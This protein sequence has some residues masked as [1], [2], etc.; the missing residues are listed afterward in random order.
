MRAPLAPPRLS[1]PRNVDADA[2]AVATSWET[3]RPEA[4]IFAFSA[5]MS[6]FPDQRM[7]HRGDRV[8]PRQ[9]FLRNER[10]EIARDRPHVAVRQLEPRPG[11]RVGE[12]VRVLV[13]APRNLF[14]GRV[15]PQRE[16]RGQHG[17]HMPLRRVEGIG[18]RRLGAFRLPLLGAGRALGQLPFVA[19]QV[20]EEVVA[21]LRRRLRPGDLRAAG[22]RVGAL[23]GAE[24]ALPAEA[25]LLDRGGFRLRAHQRGIAGAVGLAEGVT[26]GDQRD[27]FLV[28]HRH[29]GECL[30]NISRRGERIRVAVRPFRVDV[31]QAHLHGAERVLKIA[32]AGV[33]LI[34]QPFAFGAPV[35]VLIRLPDILAPAA[36]TE[37]LEAHRLRGATLPAR[38]IRSA[39]EIL[40]PYFCLIGHKQPARFVEV[41]VVRPAVERREALLAGAGAAAA[42][43][44]AV[45][46]G[47]VPRHP[48]E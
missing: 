37:G 35:D 25:L 8:L 21:P 33:A 18:D 42:V 3:D 19:E 12:F 48:N 32:V 9:L 40:R 45:G 2:Q 11:K 10:A 41:R 39:Q 47:A 1:E 38:I 6:C 31:D 34:R 27:G 5:A 43:A 20:L 23:A 26:A 29:A 36:K 17:R 15:E 14:V 28:V 24:P 13:E 4:R 22:D 7:I 46:A 44:D 30:A 16:V